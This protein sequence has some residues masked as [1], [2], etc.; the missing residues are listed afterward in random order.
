M[1]KKDAI[2]SRQ[3]QQQQQMFAEQLDAD[4]HKQCRRV[5]RGEERPCAREGREGEE[6]EEEGEKVMNLGVRVC[7]Y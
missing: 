2:Y 1:K 5:T 6:E 7:V 4:G 3:Q